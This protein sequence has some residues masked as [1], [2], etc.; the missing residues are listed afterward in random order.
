MIIFRTDLEIKLRVLWMELCLRTGKKHPSF[1]NG[2][3]RGLRELP[4]SQPHLSPWKGDGVAHSGGHLH[5]H[6]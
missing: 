5:P 3:E 1:Q 2:Q 4:A 6:G